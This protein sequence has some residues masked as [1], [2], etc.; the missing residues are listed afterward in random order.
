MEVLVL[1]T[2]SGFVGLGLMLSRSREQVELTLRSVE[3]KVDEMTSH[4]DVVNVLKVENYRLSRRVN[5]LEEK[6]TGLYESG[7]LTKQH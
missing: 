3:K 6:M 1:V 2:A 7:E 5:L 4:T